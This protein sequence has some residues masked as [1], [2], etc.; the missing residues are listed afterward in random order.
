[1]RVEL[2]ANAGAFGGFP[3]GVPYDF[4]ADRIIGGVPAAAGEQPLGRL[5][6]Q[7]AIVLSKFF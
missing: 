3:A 6:G 4:G 2:F 7:P 1:M 5:R